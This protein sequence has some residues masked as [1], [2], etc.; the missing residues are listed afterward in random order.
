MKPQASRY[1]VSYT[2]L[3]IDPEHPLIKKC[4]AM[5]MKP[6]GSPTPVS[7]THLIYLEGMTATFHKI[8]TLID[9]ATLTKLQKMLMDRIQILQQ[10]LAYYEQIKRITLLAH[11]F[12]M[13]VSYT[14]LDVYKRQA[15]PGVLHR[16]E[17]RILRAFMLQK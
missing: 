6:F 2:H 13:A 7:Y 5:G 16:E 9:D 14:H 1:P 3:R 4:V 10:H 11:H 8:A 17:N 12:S 15:F